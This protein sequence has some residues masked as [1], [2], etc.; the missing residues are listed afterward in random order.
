M[1][2]LVWPGRVKVHVCFADAAGAEI[3]TMANAR[4]KYFI[5]STPGGALQNRAH[6]GV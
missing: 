1:K 4:K 5:T 3:Q 6:A 2:F